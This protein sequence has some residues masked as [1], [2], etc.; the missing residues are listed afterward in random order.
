MSRH[1]V[2]FDREV[3]APRERVFALLSDHG[4]FTSLFGAH[5]RR[6]RNGEDEADGLGSVRRMGGGWIAIEETIVCFER[7]RTIEYAITKGGPLKNHYGSIRL[8]PLADQATHLDYRIAFD[9]R[10]PLIGPLVA[11]LLR[12]QLAR[13]APAVLA[14]LEQD[15][16][17]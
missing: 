6:I 9:G 7:P 13:Y 8:T 12:R 16:P 14:E 3:Q 11:W 17:R 5:C 1:Q 2:C 15:R 4:K 10:F